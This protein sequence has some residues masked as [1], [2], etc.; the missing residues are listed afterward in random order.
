MPFITIYTSEE[1]Q[2][3]LLE[4]NPKSVNFLKTA[5]DTFNAEGYVKA[6]HLCD[7]ST[8]QL[9]KGTEV[10]ILLIECLQH[11]LVREP[12]VAITYNLLPQLQE[13]VILIP[14][15][16]SLHIALID[17][18]KQ[19]EFL[20][21]NSEN[22]KPDFYEN[23][24]AV[25]TINKEIVMKTIGKNN[26]E[27]LKFDEAQVMF[28]ETQFKLIN[29]LAITTELYIYDDELLT[30]NDS[31]LTVPLQFAHLDNEGIIKGVVTRYTLGTEPSLQTI[32]IK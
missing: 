25:F 10:D 32:L 29:I 4:V 15:E 21:G 31:G 27:G 28:S 12:Q 23:S 5:I 17:S 1:F 2:F 9:P 14:K 11:A 19:N 6:I 7:A 22:V 3:I 30:I 20:L 8:F 13:N 16:I 26:P 24:E 18:K